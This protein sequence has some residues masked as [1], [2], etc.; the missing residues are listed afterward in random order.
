MKFDHARWSEGKTTNEVLRSACFGD[1]DSRGRERL[2]G[3]KD[4]GIS[5]VG[6][7]RCLLPIH[8][9]RTPSPFGVLSNLIFIRSIS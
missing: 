9:H 8:M 5:L 4:M 6:G 3:D 1:G 2:F 7:S